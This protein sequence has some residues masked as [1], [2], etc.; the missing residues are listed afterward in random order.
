MVTTQITLTGTIQYNEKFPPRDAKKGYVA[1]IKGRE[2]GP[3]KYKREFFGQEVTVLEG[4]EGLYERQVGDKKGGCTRYYNVVLSHPDHGL[5]VSTDCEEQVA[6]IAKLLDD[7]ISIEDA[8]EVTDLRPSQKVEGRMVFEAVA[9]TASQV[10]KAQVGATLDS[11]IESCWAVLGMLPEKDAKKVM[12]ALKAKMA[13]TK[14]AEAPM[15][16]TE[17]P[18]TE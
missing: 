11:A 10:V 14:S 15:E 6:K 2:A 18:I 16:T 8:V 13:P 4:D 5:I 7:G 9:R 3:V 17:T 1:K 12:T